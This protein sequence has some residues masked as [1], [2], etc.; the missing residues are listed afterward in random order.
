VARAWQ[1]RITDEAL[2]L[3]NLKV[4]Y[5]AGS[6]ITDNDS[7]LSLETETPH[8]MMCLSCL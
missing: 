7:K 8:N 1:V 6:S 4:G 3:V 5:A 2:V